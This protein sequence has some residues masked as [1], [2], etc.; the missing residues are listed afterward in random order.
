MESLR[1][2]GAST[3]WTPIVSTGLAVLVAPFLQFTF[4]YSQKNQVLGENVTYA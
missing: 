3:G 1:N 4:D 2:P